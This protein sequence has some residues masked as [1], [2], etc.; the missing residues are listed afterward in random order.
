MVLQARSKAPPYESFFKKEKVLHGRTAA[1]DN[2]LAIT[3]GYS[4]D[5]KH[6]RGE[7]QQADRSVWN[8]A[9]GAAAANI[10]YI[11]NQKLNVNEQK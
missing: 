8:F 9:S 3:K 6:N 4:S 5:I 2:N 11:T 10:K 7:E 1:E